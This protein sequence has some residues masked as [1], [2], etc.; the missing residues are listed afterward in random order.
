MCRYGALPRL[1]AKRI[2]QAIGALPITKN[3][4][5]QCGAIVDNEAQLH[6]SP[7]VYTESP[8]RAIRRS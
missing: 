5:A 2:A 8:T 4:I 1:S 6:I 7:P 3:D